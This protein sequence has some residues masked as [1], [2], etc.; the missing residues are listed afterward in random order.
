M[1]TLGDRFYPPQQHETVINNTQYYHV[2]IIIHTRLC[3]TITSFGCIYISY[4][5]I[6]NRLT[7]HNGHLSKT[8][9]QYRY[10][11][12]THHACKKKKKTQDFAGR[13]GFPSTVPGV[14]RVVIISMTTFVTSKK[15]V[16]ILII[17]IIYNIIY[18]LSNIESDLPPGNELFVLKNAVYI[19]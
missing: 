11:V 9:S 10:T 1:K 7:E 3:V 4:Y 19:I 17:I 12:F 5:Y 8:S 16:N 18:V 15:T 6:S 14:Q 2:P 13:H